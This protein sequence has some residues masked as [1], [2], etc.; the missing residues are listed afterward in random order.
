MVTSGWNYSSIKSLHWFNIRLCKLFRKNYL[1]FW[2]SKISIQ[3]H[4]Y[5]NHNCTEISNYHPIHVCRFFAGVELY[6][7]HLI[8]NFKKLETIMIDFSSDLEHGFVIK[9]FREIWRILTKSIDR[10]KPILLN[11]RGPVINLDFQC[12]IHSIYMLINLI[13]YLTKKISF[14]FMKK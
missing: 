9:T 12:G 3:F 8:N 4:K 10:M 14:N 7:W 11:P 5:V 6:W 2:L 1:C 13:K